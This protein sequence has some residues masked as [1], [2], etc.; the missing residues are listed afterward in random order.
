MNVDKS[1][2]A[3]MPSILDKFR[4]L[5]RLENENLKFFSLRTVLFLPPKAFDRSPFDQ[6]SGIDY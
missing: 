2:R 1:E 5:P 3:N 6:I 4:F